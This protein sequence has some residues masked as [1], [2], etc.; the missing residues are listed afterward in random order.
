MKGGARFAGAF[1]HFG[2]MVIATKVFATIIAS[3][4]KAD[5]L[6]TKPTSV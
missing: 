2:Q 5:L 4:E 6:F 1:M 3:K